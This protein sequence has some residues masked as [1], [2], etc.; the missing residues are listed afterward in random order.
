MS[1]VAVPVAASAMVTSLLVAEMFGPTFQGE[2]PSC[3]QQAVFV[4][5]SRCNLSCP[6]CDT[7]YTWDWSRYEAKAEARRLPVDE[8]AEW[9]LAQQP[10]LVVITGGEPLLQQRHL[11]P[12]VALLAGHGRRVEIET[13][14]T[15]Y[16][17]PALIRAVSA[18]NVSP[19]LARFAGTR[20]R[21]LNPAAL[22]A[23]VACGKAVFKFVV[24][25]PGEVD[26]VAAL[27]HD[28]H[29]APVWIMPEAV[30]ADGVVAGLRVVADETLRRGWNLTGRL[31]LLLWGDVRG[32]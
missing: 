25:E 24:A 7:P 4:R 21:T 8:V 15:V 1:G 3:G 14:G 11:I 16:P 29:L 31:H 26:Q 17:E 18:F 2:G 27:A 28:H 10:R 32:R 6:P 13:N 12:L 19:K 22:A 9:V 23:F 30:T 5:L 20:E